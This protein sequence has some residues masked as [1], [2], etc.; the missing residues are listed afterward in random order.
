MAFSPTRDFSNVMKT[1]MKLLAGFLMVLASLF[2]VISRGRD[3]PE[4]A[5][6]MNPPY[7]GKTGPRASAVTADPPSGFQVPA[8]AVRTS[9]ASHASPAAAKDAAIEAIHE[10]ATS[11]DPAQLVVIRP[12]LT[13]ADAEL[14]AAAVDAMIVLGDASAA[15]MLRQAATT[16]GSGEEA[17]AMI[18]AADYV[19][20]PP[21]NLKKL[22]RKARDKPL[23]DA[24][25]AELKK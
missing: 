13:S 19:E 14:R 6:V 17:E 8:G 21:A 15:A 9:A 23:S 12:Y 7:H 11:Y 22:T 24:P 20:L 10:A 2:I 25:A 3:K 5:S 4:P 1:R 16:I 18:Q